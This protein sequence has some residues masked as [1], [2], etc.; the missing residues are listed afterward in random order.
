MTFRDFRADVSM[1]LYKKS[2]P[3]RGIEEAMAETFA[4]LEVNGIKGVPTRIAAER[5]TRVRLAGRWTPRRGERTALG[6]GDSWPAGPD[7]IQ[8]GRGLQG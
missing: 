2:Y 7:R 4:P 3:V 8:A 6:V 1:T 5:I